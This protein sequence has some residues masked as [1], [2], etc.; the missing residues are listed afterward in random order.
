MAESK[1]MTLFRN[2]ISKSKSNSIIEA[3]FDVLYPSGF[4]TLD[5]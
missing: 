4:L 1:L 2:K 3:G 5:Y